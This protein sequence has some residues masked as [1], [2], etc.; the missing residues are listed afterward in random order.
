[1]DRKEPGTETAEFLELL[2]AIDNCPTLYSCWD[3]KNYNSFPI[4]D[5]EEEEFY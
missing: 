2:V 3:S 4:F 5:K 1:M